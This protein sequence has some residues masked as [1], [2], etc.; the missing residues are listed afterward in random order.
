LEQGVLERDLRHVVAGCSVDN[1]H[2]WISI[3]VGSGQ[4]PSSKATL[5]LITLIC[6]LVKYS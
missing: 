2:L 3:L 5:Y 1:S 6:N 4:A